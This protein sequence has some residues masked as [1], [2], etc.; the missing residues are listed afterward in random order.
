MEQIVK[1]SVG[2]IVLDPKTEKILLT[3]KLAKKEFKA[4]IIKSLL[5]LLKIKPEQAIKKFKLWWFTKGKIEKWDTKE[6]T[7]LNEIEEEWWINPSDL[8]FIQRLWIFTKQKIYGVKE[9]EMFLYTLHKEYSEINPTDI[10]HIAAFIDLDK[11]SDI[12][13]NKEERKF[14]ISI[15]H[16]IQ[17]TLTAHKKITTLPIN[18]TVDVIE[19]DVGVER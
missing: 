8:I 14:L 17:K 19:V 7:A 6:Q 3:K 10:R 15:Q 9:I 18:E 12:I 13:Q 1:R 2:G 16:E 4:H 11:A 5:S